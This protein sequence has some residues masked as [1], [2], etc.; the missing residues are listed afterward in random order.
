ISG[1][2]RRSLGTRRLRG[3]RF[4]DETAE[5]KGRAAATWGPDYRPGEGRSDEANAP[6]PRRDPADGGDPGA[7]RRLSGVRAP[8]P[9]SLVLRESAG[10]E[11]LDGNN[12]LGRF[13][14]ERAGLVSAVSDLARAKRKK[15][16][17]VFDGPPEAGRPRVQSL[18]DVT[19]VFA[20][21]K[22]ADE[23]I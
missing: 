3:S 16:T 23:E 4:P 22:S 5:T 18:G 6:D 10:V 15:L 17:V 20:A 1:E 7:R 9:R 19:L 21:P 2:S 13:G 12:L 11:L 14:G 8:A